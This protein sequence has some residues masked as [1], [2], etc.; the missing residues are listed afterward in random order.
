MASLAYAQKIEPALEGLT[1][2]A[3]Y[4]QYVIKADGEIIGEIKWASR[5]KN[6]GG[7]AWAAHYDANFARRAAGQANAHPIGTKSVVYAKTLPAL[8]TELR[9]RLTA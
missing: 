2:P 1:L 8:L 9:N 4:N 3:R 5:P 6:A 7:P